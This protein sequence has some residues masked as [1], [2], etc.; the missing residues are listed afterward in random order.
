MLAPF[1]PHAGSNNNVETH[2]LGTTDLA[3][4][5]LGFGAW[6]IGGADWRFG[7][8]TQDDD[9]SVAA[10]KRAIAKGINW[11]DTAA[12]YGLGHSEEVVARALAGIPASERPYV[13]TKCALIPDGQGGMT[14][15]LDPAS[16]RKECEASLRRLKVETIDLYQVHWSTDEISDIDAG[17]AT[18]ADLQRE[19]KVRWIGVSNFSAEEMERAR[20]I[21]PIASDQPPYSLLRRDVEQEVLPYCRQH[22]IGVIVYAPMQSGLLTGAMTKERAAALPENDWRSRNAEF[23]EPKLSANLALVDVLR[24]VGKRHNASPGEVAIAWTLRDDVVTGAIVGARS[25]EQVD[26]WLG[27]TSLKLSGDE[28]AEIEAAIPAPVAS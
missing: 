27:A 2:Q 5:R 1:P 20:K 16:L 11:I 8:G 22:K 25:P 4:T 19:G 14:E 18:L 23:Q 6:A 28:I 13:F 26:G 24:T 7:W 21:A 3:I 15:S 9:A 17:W 12:A 10:I